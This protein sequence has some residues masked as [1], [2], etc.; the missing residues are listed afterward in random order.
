MTASPLR[1]Q[2]TRKKGGGYLW[3]G[4]DKGNVFISNSLPVVYV[5]RPTIWG[6][7]FQLNEGYSREQ[8]VNSYVAWV[9]LQPSPFFDAVKRI[10][11]GKNLACWC[12]LD[13]PCHAD[14]LLA[15]ANK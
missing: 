2:R 15:I 8:S 5:G 13:Q 1:L 10:L 11:K 6:S 3:P 14:I 9:E 12:P 4:M 7:M